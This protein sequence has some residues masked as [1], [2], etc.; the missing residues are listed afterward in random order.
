MGGRCVACG[1][2]E[3]LQFDHVDRTTKAFDISSSWGRKWETIVAELAKCQL[4]C[5]DCHKAKSDAEATT[6]RHGTH[7]M[8]RAGCRC[9]PCR[10]G[11]AVYMKPI[12]AA[13]R[14]HTCA[15]CGRR[16]RRCVES[17]AGWLCTECA[18]QSRR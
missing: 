11:N 8:C 3:L 6:R 13:S 12:M 17:D 1:S 5:R 15:G 18:E 10:E 14:R 4:L 16:R 2:T 9:D 7:P